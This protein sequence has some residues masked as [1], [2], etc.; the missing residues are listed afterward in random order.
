MLHLETPSPLST[1]YLSLPF[2]KCLLDHQVTRSLKLQLKVISFSFR[3]LGFATG[4][5]LD[6][7]SL[8]LGLQ[9]VNL[10]ISFIL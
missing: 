1:I 6:F 5:S 7:L 8:G 3:I 4:K 9:S 2:I 10:P